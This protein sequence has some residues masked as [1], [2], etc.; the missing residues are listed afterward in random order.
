MIRLKD[1]FLIIWSVETQIVVKEKLGRHRVKCSGLRV[2]EDINSHSLWGGLDP[3]T[4]PS[5]SSRDRCGAVLAW[6]WW[7][8]GGYRGTIL[9]CVQEKWPAEPQ[10]NR[11]EASD[12]ALHL[13]VLK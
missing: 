4:S 1:F 6:G 3:G 10:S 2:S 13:R 5:P 12:V 9:M 8:P 11:L 7:E